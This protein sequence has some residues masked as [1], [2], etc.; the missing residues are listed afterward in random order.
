MYASVCDMIPSYVSEEQSVFLKCVL[1]NQNL[2]V[3]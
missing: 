2:A 3:T 1:L